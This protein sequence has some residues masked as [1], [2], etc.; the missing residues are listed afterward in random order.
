[1]AFEA[2]IAAHIDF[3]IDTNYNFADFDSFIG[4]FRSVL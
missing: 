4:T 3:V 2:A 1:M